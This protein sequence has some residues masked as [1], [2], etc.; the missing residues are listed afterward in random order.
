M[1]ESFQ[2]TLTGEI[3]AG[4][5][6]PV[7]RQ[8]AGDELARTVFVHKYPSLNQLPR[9][10][11]YQSCATLLSRSVTLT[12]LP[13]RQLPHMKIIILKAISAAIACS[14][15]SAAGVGV[16]QLDNWEW[17]NPLPTGAGLSSVA[18]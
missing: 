11:C 12:R 9:C 6:P 17:R 18:Y 13:S 1:K 3:G 7:R 2:L 4:L 10:R 15:I 16:D 5:S 14:L 8:S